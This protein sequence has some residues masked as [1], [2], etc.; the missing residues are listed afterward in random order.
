ML[1]IALDQEE[2]P[3]FIEDHQT[4]EFYQVLK[5]LSDNLQEEDQDFPTPV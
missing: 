3:L 1:W 4:G 5:V 2:K